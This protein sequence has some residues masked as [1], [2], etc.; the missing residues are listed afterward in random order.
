M[1][2][3]NHRPWQR[4]MAVDKNPAIVRDFRK[5]FN[6]RSIWLL[7]TIGFVAGLLQAGLVS[8]VCGRLFDIGQ[9]LLILAATA[10]INIGMVIAI[11]YRLSKPLYTILAAIAHKNNELTTTTPPNPNT[12]YNE[13]TGLKNILLSIYES[14]SKSDDNTSSNQ[15]SSVLT[16][17][18]NNTSCGVV[19][20]DQQGKIVSAN[21]AAPIA[22]TQDGE[23]FLA[24][25][26]VDDNN[27]TNWL[28]TLEDKGINAEKRWERVG[29][30]TDLVK[31]SRFYDIIASYERGSNAETVVVLIDQTDRYQPEEDDLNF[32]AFAAHE[33]RGPITVIRGY[34]DIF[35]QE[36]GKR[37]TGDEPELLSRL[38]V[39]ASRLSSYIN[40]ILNVAK[41]DRHH[42]QTHLYED[43][44]AAIYATI[45]DDMMLRANTQHRLIN[46]SIPKDL[47]TVAADR[48]SIGEALGNLI[49]NAIKYSFEGGLIQVSAQT[50][51][52][53]VEISVKDNGIGMPSNVVSN[54]FRKFYRSHRSR[55]AVAGTGIGL[56][57]TKAFIESHGG[58]I[59]VTSKENEGSTFSFTLPIYSTVSD[60]L[61]EDGQLNQ[62][63]V[64]KGDNWIKN[65]TM[66][67]R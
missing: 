36:V 27:I 48:G 31:K 5:R 6:A 37:L 45:A 55:E 17:G 12:S 65:H 39:S 32:I 46:V 19:I 56:Y 13:R 33:L 10:T 34:L 40:N 60:R 1:G 67:R 26:F 47:P 38:S 22:Y 23:A 2:E 52:D 51:G 41:F 64:K 15:A 3:R 30:Q 44:V 43:T 25:N 49:D 29:V 14:S 53:F 4:I 66:Y 11:F 16:T 58:S 61:L 62:G 20:Y 35:E 28:S 54:L 21:K 24:L 42:L 8:L 9:L 7:V 18:L 57:I 59:S 50:K 63:L